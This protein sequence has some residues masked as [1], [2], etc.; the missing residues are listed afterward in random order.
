M[1]IITSKI[2]KLKFNNKIKATLKDAQTGEII[3]TVVTPNTVTNTGKQLLLDSLGET[4]IGIM[5]GA[6][7]L[8]AGSTSAGT[9]L[10]KTELARNP[11][12]YVRAGQTG[13]FSVFFNTA[14]ANSG[15]ITEIGFFGGTSSYTSVNTG[16][17]FNRILLTSGITKTSNYT[18]TVDLD[19]GF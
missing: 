9:I 3:N 1:S 8:G 11:S 2:L 13:T 12:I 7:G 17:M 15:A 10:L 5:H 16:L 19:V 14:Q 4:N 6:V 18:L